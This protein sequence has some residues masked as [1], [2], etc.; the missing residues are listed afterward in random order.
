LLDAEAV[1]RLWGIRKG[2]PNMNYDKLSRALRYYY[3]KNII[4]KVIGQKFV[5]RFVMDGKQS[6]GGDLGLGMAGNPELVKYA[7]NKAQN[8]I[9]NGGGEKR[10]P[11]APRF[12]REWTDIFAILTKCQFR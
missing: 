5:Y 7:I 9:M 2:K 10:A 1:A 12:E 3:D 11:E 8:G 6:G 4:K